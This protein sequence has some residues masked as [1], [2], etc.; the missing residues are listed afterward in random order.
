MVLEAFLGPLE[1]RATATAEWGESRIDMVSYLHE[2]LPPQDLI[3]SVRAVLVR[4]GCI[5]VLHNAHGVHPVPGGRREPSET[6][7][8][9]LQREVM[10]EAGC[11]IEEPIQ[12][13]FIH[14][15]HL[16]PCPEGYA[17]PYPDF[18]QAVFAA[19]AIQVQDAFDPEGWEERVEFVPFDEVRLEDFEPVHRVFVDAALE[20]FA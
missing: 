8:D 20:C 13:G 10:E 7:L 19:R 5:A 2:S 15:R 14:F 3:T 4:D 17:Y 9:T 11:V 1:A 6:L 16:T 18:C 12:L